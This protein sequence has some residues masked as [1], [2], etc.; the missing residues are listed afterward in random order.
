[1]IKGCI[2]RLPC[3]RASHAGPGPQPHGPTRRPQ[4]PHFRP[5]LLL[6]LFLAWRVCPRLLYIPP[7]LRTCSKFNGFSNN[8]QVLGLDN[9]HA[10]RKW[11]NSQPQK[12]RM[13]AIL[14]NMTH[15]NGRTCD[16]RSPLLHSCCGILLGEGYP[17]M[18]QNKT[19]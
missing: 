10:S 8:L 15:A 17:R 11:R 6:F 9:L 5:L 2:R 14:S 12:P 13:H 4:Q 1:M 19:L 3:A 16:L 7:H 18:R